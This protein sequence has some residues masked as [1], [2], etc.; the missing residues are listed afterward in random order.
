MASVARFSHQLESSALRKKNGLP[1]SG[2]PFRTGFGCLNNPPESSRI[3]PN[4][5]GSQG[6]CAIHHNQ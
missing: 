1:F 5:K 4:P 2:S 6:F 3:V